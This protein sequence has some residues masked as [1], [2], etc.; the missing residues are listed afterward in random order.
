METLKASGVDCAALAALAVS[1]VVAL[2][3]RLKELGITKIGTRAK[4]VAEL[5]ATNGNAAYR[6]IQDK[7]ASNGS[8]RTAPWRVVV[9]HNPCVFVR[10]RPDA[11]SGE[12]AKKMH[13]DDFLVGEET[14]SGW[15][16]L[17][18]EEG[19]VL[20]D[21]SQ[22]GLGVLLR[23]LPPPPLPPP[24]DLPPLAVMATDGLGNRLRVVLSFA[25]IARERGRPLL[26]QWPVANV[27]P[28]RFTDAFEAL[29]GVTFTEDIAKLGIRPQFAPGSHDFHREV[30][31]QGERACTDCYGI[32]RPSAVVRARV[33]ATLAK[34]GPS[35]LSV[36]LRRTDHWGGPATDEEF[37]AF[38]AAH[39]TSSRRVFLATD[40]AET[41]Q[42]VRAAAEKAGASVVTATDIVAD[43]SKLRQTSLEDSAV[44]IFVAAR[45]D[46]PFKG[47]YS[48]SFSDTI[49]RLRELGGELGRS[50]AQD[51]HKL[52]D[53]HMQMAVTL[54]TPGGHRTHSPGCPMESVRYQPS[55]QTR[56]R[57]SFHIVSTSPMHRANMVTSEILSVGLSSCERSTG[58]PTTPGSAATAG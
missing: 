40:N 42:K 19:W 1:D 45:A 55:R 53:P 12:L 43:R 28:G 27:C 7:S 10:E 54:H 6:T 50:H 34:L 52:T 33:D 22:V 16:K 25:R 26:V 29:P 48:S 18:D 23:A 46:G 39:A 36:H 44:D 30:R 8:S 58:I 47:T 2:N 17:H 9:V 20:R 37:V 38:V 35:F 24:P 14:P 4:V 13:G 51:E 32:L 5:L 11:R 31:A 15:L 56:P 3:E 49:L 57:P 21:G 41:Q